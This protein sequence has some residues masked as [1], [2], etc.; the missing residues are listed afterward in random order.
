MTLARV[1]VQQGR[2]DEAFDVTRRALTT[3]PRGEPQ[4]VV[5]MALL[6]VSADRSQE[7]EGLLGE[8]ARK[9]AA[10]APVDAARGVLAEHAGRTAEAEALY[11]KSL[12]SD[13]GFPVPLG[14]LFALYAARGKEP[15]LLPLVRRGVAANDR[16]VLHRNWLGLILMREGDVVGAERELLEALELAPDFA[17]TMANLGSLYGRVGR[18]EEAVA[19]LSRAVRIEPTKLESRVNL[20]AALAKL[21]RLDE[22]IARLEEARALGIRSTELL[23]A[24][25]LAYAQSGRAPEAIAA[26]TESLA[27]RPDQPQVEALLRELRL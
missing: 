22:A 6:A 25:G 24:V 10:D 23:N 5:Q 8:L 14:R 3:S 7:A 17:G 13:P 18:L 21:G 4:A 2:V 1:L 11:R 20:G 16:S 15:E 27:L 26:L 12:L 19:I 9:G